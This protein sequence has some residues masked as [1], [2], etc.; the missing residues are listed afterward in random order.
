MALKD[1]LS[2]LMTNKVEEP[3]KNGDNYYEINIQVEE[4]SNDYDVDKL[5][6]KIKT[7][8]HQDGMYRNVNSI[9]ILR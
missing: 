6:N 1:I 4:L 3:T 2:H 8:I 5:A 7:M 9:N